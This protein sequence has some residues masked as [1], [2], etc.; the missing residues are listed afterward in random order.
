MVNQYVVL[1]D[2]VESRE[3]TDRETLNEGLTEVLNY[4]NYTHREAIDTSFERIKGI[5]EFGGVLGQLAPLY[6]VIVE[7]L[8]EIHPVRVRFGIAGG[9]VDVNHQTDTVSE[10]DGPAFHRAD[11][12][13]AEAEAD[14]LYAYVD[15]D[16]AIDPLVANSVNLLLM[17]RERLTDRQ[18]ETIRAYERHGTQEAAADALDVRQQ[19]VS[20]TLKR[21]DYGR[22]RKIRT[23][24]RKALEE[25]YD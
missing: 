5:D 1:A 13:L 9:K 2:I 11:R 24:L 22:T 10:M 4:V 3:V 17:Y 7:I 16:S 14:D 18:V 6:D 12:F 19:S 15:T 23:Q 25:I 8:N 20:N 21:A